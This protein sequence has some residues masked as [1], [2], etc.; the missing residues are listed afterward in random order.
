[1]IHIGLISC[2]DSY[3]DKRWPL[4]FIDV[5]A[6]EKSRLKVDRFTE[7]MCRVAA[8]S[9]FQF[10]LAC[11]GCSIARAPIGESASTRA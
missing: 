9:H 11:M 7:A 1:M 8:E 3:V 2:S 4:K 5:C 6:L 10:N